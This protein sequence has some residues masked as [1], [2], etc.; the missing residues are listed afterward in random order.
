MSIGSPSWRSWVLDANEGTKLLEA[1]L[2]EGINFIDTC[3]F[4]SAGKSEEL[5]GE[6]VER[7]S[8]RDEVVIATKVGNPVLPG[9]NGRGYS[10]KHILAAVE[11]SLRRL[12]TD[13][14]DLYQT[15]IWDPDT[16]IEEMIEAFDLLVRQGKVLHVGATDI[17]CFQLA[18]AIYGARAR[19]FTA[20]STIQIHYNAV[21]REDERE[22]IPFCRQE[23]LGLLTYSPLARGFLAGRERRIAR[24]TTER[25]RTDTYAWS[26]YGRP[27]DNSVAIIIENCADR[28][29]VEPAQIALAWVL[30]RQPSAVPL[31]GFTSERQLMAAIEAFKISLSQTEL[32][33]IDQA[34][35]VRPH[36]GHF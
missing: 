22:L 14:I 20:F 27:E 24:D 25:S 30:A 7:L 9:P 36:G 19:G 5:I 15:H 4:Y 35:G 23:G 33:E 3:N 11:G 17:P 12:R 32:S 21:W 1:A 13:R 26:W 10:K 34:Y 31:V 28:H 29:G 18:K 8:I 16:N 2:R 6:V